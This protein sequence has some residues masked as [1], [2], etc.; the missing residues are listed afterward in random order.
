MSGKRPPPSFVDDAV[1]KFRIYEAEK[2]RNFKN[3]LSNCKKSCS[4]NGGFNISSLPESK[5][6]TEN[7]LDSCPNVTKCDTSHSESVRSEKLDAFNQVST[8]KL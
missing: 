7:G 4:S 6:S 1:E 5:L 8:L 3:G 2:A